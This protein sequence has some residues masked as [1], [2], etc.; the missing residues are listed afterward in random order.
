VRFK[1]HEART[2]AVEGSAP[3]WNEQVRHGLGR[4]EL[5]AAPD[6]NGL[7][8]CRLTAAVP[9]QL[10]GPGCWSS[11]QRLNPHFPAA[12]PQ[13]SFPVFA[14]EEEATPAALQHSDA[15]LT[16]SV[17]DEVGRWC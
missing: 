3:L 1:E 11:P 5:G 2:S 10:L 17:F 13:L 6:G 4:W 15:M 7:A 9:D 12:T 14:P 8:A 16:V